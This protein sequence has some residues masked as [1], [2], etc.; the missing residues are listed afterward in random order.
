MLVVAKSGKARMAI[1]NSR[2]KRKIVKR[3]DKKRKRK[4]IQMIEGTR[5]VIKITRNDRE[6]VRKDEME[7]K[8]DVGEIARHSNRKWEKDIEKE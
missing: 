5:Y 1:K 2:R 6:E 8:L 7:K 4:D 3:R